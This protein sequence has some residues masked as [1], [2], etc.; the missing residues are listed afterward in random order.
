MSAGEHDTKT[1]VWVHEKN[2]ITLTH[3][4]SNECDCETQG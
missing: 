1:E 4:M 3:V 2:T